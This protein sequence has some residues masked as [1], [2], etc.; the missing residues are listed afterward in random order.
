MNSF[1]FWVRKPLLTWRFFQWGKSHWWWWLLFSWIAEKI[2][3]KSNMSFDVLVCVLKGTPDSS[4]KWG[5]KGLQKLS[6]LRGY[7]GPGPGGHVDHWFLV[8]VFYWQK[9]LCRCFCYISLANRIGSFVCVF[10]SL[11]KIACETTLPQDLLLWDFREGEKNEVAIDIE[12]Y[13]SHFASF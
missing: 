13:G 1:T 2:P 10:F 3:E 7:F 4:K 5:L 9:N 12:I 8:F 6:P 11:A